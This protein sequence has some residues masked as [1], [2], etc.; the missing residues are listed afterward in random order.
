M[1]IKTSITLTEELLKTIDEFVD[2]RMNRSL[3]LESAAWEYIARL[4]RAQENE[5]DLAILNEQADYL[6]TEM[7]DVLEYQVGI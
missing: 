3:F 1:K 2:E 5:R 6:N 4:R 7:L